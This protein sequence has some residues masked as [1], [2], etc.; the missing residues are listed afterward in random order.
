M[1]QILPKQK[2]YENVANTII[3]NLKKRQIEGFYCPDKESALKKALELM[4]KGVSIGWGGSMTVVET[5]LMDAIQNGEYQIINREDAKT[6]EEQRKIYG[7]L[8]CSDF[9]LILSRCIQPIKRLP[10]LL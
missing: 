10:L 7:E 6:P 9:F 4:P 1:E 2:Y 8:C 5:G 3:K